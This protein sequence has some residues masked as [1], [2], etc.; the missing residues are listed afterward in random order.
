MN[1]KHWPYWLRGGVI[2]FALA[3]ILIS[4]D[5]MC[6]RSAM[7]TFIQSGGGQDFADIQCIPLDWPTWPVELTIPASYSLS[8]IPFT[9]LN[10]LLW[11]FIGSLIGAFVGYIKSR[12]KKFNS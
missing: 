9:V 6:I 1:W 3:A 12:R 11:F 8:A 5:L 7:K 10:S 2:A 4:L